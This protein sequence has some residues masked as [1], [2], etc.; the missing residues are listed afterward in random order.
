MKPYHSLTYLSAALL[1]SG[2]SSL[3]DNALVGDDGLI[4]DRSRDYQLSQTV[5][6]LQVP[7][8]LDQET[9]QDLLVVPDIGTAALDSEQKFKVPRPDFFYADAGNETVNL[10]RKERDKLIVVEEPV[11]DVWLKVREFWNYNAVDLVL[12]DPAQGLMETQWIRVNDEEP[13]FFSTLLSKLTFQAIEGPIQDKLQIRVMAG[14]NDRQSAISLKHIR[15]AQNEAEVAID[16]SEEAKDVSYKS[17][18]MYEL[19]HYLSKSSN[20]N[21]ARALQARR[22]LDNQRSLLGRDSEGNPVLKMTT[23]IDRAWSQV[24]EA[25]QTASIDVGSSNR[26][27]GKYYITYTTHT[28]FDEKTEAGGIWGF[29]KWLH[30]DDR[31]PITIDTDLFTGGDSKSEEDQIIYSGKD[32]PN[33]DP[34]DLSK[35]E[36]YKI[37][38]G[39]K[40]VYVF[41]TD[42]SQFKKNEE[43]GEY[44]HTGRY[45]VKLS[46]RRSGVFISV[47]MDDSEQAPAIV[48]E[49]ILWEIKDNLSAG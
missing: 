10:A 30:S 17:E 12:S 24:G 2:C 49:E 38:L 20:R 7:D 4:H 34:N 31:K 15:V 47:H 33:E 36:G 6:R 45:Q 46:R 9:I 8:H 29:I 39:G 13:G 23:D 41:E 26:D 40:V 43:T 32:D 16:W 37:W 18:M 22:T 35:K 44:D 1:L 28:P 48:A 42:K 3:T 25:M 19:L 14:E 27:F 11:S 21:T 5:P